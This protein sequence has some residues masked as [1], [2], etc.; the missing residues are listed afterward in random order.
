MEMNIMNEILIMQLEKERKN[1]ITHISRDSRMDVMGLYNIKSYDV[2]IDML[3]KYIR[4]CNYDTANK[5]RLL[6]LSKY[7]RRMPNEIK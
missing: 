5:L 4:G 6:W 3:S 2:V 1:L 7:I